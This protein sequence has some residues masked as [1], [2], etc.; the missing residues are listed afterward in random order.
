MKGNSSVAYGVL[1]SFLMGGTITGLISIVTMYFTPLVSAIIWAYPVTLVPTVFFMKSQG[2]KNTTIA[3][4]LLSAAFALVVLMAT[5]FMLSYEVDHAPSDESLVEPVLASTAGF[6]V[7]GLLFYGIIKAL[8]ADKFLNSKASP[9]KSA[10][11][12]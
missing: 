7:S 3:K 4:F 11:Q 6:V 5:T 9:K 8:G 12:E 10:Q 1:K 2:K